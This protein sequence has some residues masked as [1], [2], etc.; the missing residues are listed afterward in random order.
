MCDLM[1]LSLTCQHYVD[2][3]PVLNGVTVCELGK[4]VVAG[5][6]I[7][8][9]LLQ[10]IA[11]RVFRELWGGEGRGGE[12]RGGEGRGGEGMEGKGRGG[13]DE[14]VRQQRLNCI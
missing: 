13:G 1:C 5:V 7:E 3:G 12:G 10:E 14:S 6:L 8:E 9:N 11:I 4:G 2:D